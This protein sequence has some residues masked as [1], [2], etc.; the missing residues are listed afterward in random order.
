MYSYVQAFDRLGDLPAYD[1]AQ[2]QAARQSGR[3]A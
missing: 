3:F 1:S 2:M